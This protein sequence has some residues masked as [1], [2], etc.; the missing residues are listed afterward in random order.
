[1]K[2]PRLTC[3]EEAY[4]VNMTLRVKQMS[5]TKFFKGGNCIMICFERVNQ[6]YE[7]CFRR[8]FHYER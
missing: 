5:A 1:M 6:C 4:G 3:N 8:N 7:F 2:F